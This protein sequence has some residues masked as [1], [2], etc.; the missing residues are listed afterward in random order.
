MP[1]MWENSFKTHTGYNIL[2][3]NI[4]IEKKWKHFGKQERNKLLKLSIPF[5]HD[6]QNKENTS[7]KKL[8]RS[9]FK[10]LKVFLLT[11]H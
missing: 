11:S 9:R 2:V 8:T 6:Q 4:K 7:W 5:A 3:F 10:Q 1:R